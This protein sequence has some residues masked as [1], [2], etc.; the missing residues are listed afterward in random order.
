MVYISNRTC[1][2]QES[3]IFYIIIRTLDSQI[4]NAIIKDNKL[5]FVRVVIP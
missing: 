2:F 4:Q 5:Y 3:D 1:A